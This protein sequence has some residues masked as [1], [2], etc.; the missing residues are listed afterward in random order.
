MTALGLLLIIFIAVVV[1]GG[2]GIT[3]MF[4][5]KNQIVKNVCFYFLAALGMLL[6]YTSATSGPRNY[7][8]E[9][10]VAWTVGFVPIAAIILKVKKPQKAMISYVLA[11]FAVIFGIVDIFF[12]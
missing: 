7:I 3:F 8:A 5:S 10:V 6:A 9:Q 12:I 2:L 1:V 4:L 11:A